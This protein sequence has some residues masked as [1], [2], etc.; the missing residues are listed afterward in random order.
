MFG[1]ATGDQLYVD[2][3]IDGLDP[4]PQ[5][6]TYVIWLMIKGNKGYPLSPVTVSESGQFH[7]RFSVPS[8]VL[9][10]AARTQVVDVSIAQNDQGPDQVHAQVGAGGGAGAAG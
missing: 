9:P 5:G 6:N 7:D 8:A 4:A 1:L 10:I 3:S 2:V